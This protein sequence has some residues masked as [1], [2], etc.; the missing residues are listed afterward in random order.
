MSKL[1]IQ[2]QVYEAKALAS[3]IAADADS[4]QSMM[5]EE[6]WDEAVDTMQELQ[7]NIA[8]IQAMFEDN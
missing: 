2:S 6:Q 5:E 1:K 3:S 7:D 8:K 4:F